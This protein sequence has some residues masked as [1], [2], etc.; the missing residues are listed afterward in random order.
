MIFHL[1]AKS[2]LNSDFQ[3]SIDFMKMIKYYIFLMIIISAECYSQDNSWIVGADGNYNMPIGT[4]SKRFEG[5]IGGI[6]YAGKKSNNDWT[7]V[8]KFEYF[9]LNDVN[10]DYSNKI[11]KTEELG[12]VREYKFDLP[13]L[14]MD[15]TVAGL[16][17]EARYNLFNSEIVEANINFGFGFYY[18]QHTRNEYKDSLFADTS[19]QG[20]FAL[21]EVLNVPKLEQKDW[22]GG[23]NIGADINFPLF[24]TIDFNLGFNY[25][26]IITELWPALALNLENVSGLQFLDI[27]AG[28]RVNL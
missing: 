23:I 13:K 21:V 6:V 26:I 12:V 3:F 25:K 1:A 27:R 5:S 22:S 17:V 28:F 10:K 8:G 7:W 19:G 11:V 9:K 2:Q 15:L 16:S 14:K 24:S 20:N 4:L 18:W